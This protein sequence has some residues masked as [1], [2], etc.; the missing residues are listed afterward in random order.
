MWLG[1]M[2]GVLS[3]AA[4]LEGTGLTRDQKRYFLYP[5]PATGPVL[6]A[7]LAAEN[8]PALLLAIA[9][10]ESA[11]EPAVRSRAGALGFMQDQI[12]EWIDQSPEIDVKHISTQ[13]GM[14]EGKHT[15]PHL[16]VTIFY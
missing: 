12:N 8:D 10:N 1:D 15:E 2:H 14:F 5:L 9:R 6:D 7:L 16:I 3:V 4:V 11:F 13:V